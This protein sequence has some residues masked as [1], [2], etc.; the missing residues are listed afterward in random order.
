MY[1]YSLQRDQASL[2]SFRREYEL[3]VRAQ[4]E[5]CEAAAVTTAA[6]ALTRSE[7]H[8]S[9]I[10]LFLHLSLVRCTADEHPIHITK[11]ES[12]RAL[13]PGTEECQSIRIAICGVWLVR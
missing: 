5:R 1:W 10:P 2:D 7:E 12:E 11:L 9:L 4:A 6:A 3:G 8:C 13:W